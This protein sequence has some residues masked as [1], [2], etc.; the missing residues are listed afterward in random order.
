MTDQQRPGSGSEL[1]PNSGYEPETGTGN[2]IAA[3]TPGTSGGKKKGKSLDDMKAN[4][5]SVFGHGVGKIAIIAAVVTVVIVGALAVRGLTARSNA[6]AKATKV[7]VPDAPAPQITVDPIS[8]K[9]AERRAHQDALEA[10]Q[11][12]KAGQSYQPAFDPNISDAAAQAKANPGQA[13]AQ[14]GQVPGQAGVVPVVPSQG[15]Q[16]VQV[17]VPAGQSA[18]TAEEQRQQQE[19][20]Q[21]QKARAAYVT[22][23]K[24]GVKESVGELLGEHGKT[25]IRNI[26]TYSAVSYL[27]QPKAAS[28]TNSSSGAQPAAT[29]SANAGTAA[30][31]NSSQD[32]KTVFKAGKAI[33]AETDA[34][35]DT[36]DGSDVFAT[37]RGGAYD[38]A[39][40]I[41]KV[42]QTPRNIRFHFNTL[43]PQDS[44]P[45]LNINAIAIRE[46]DA[47]Q[48][49][50]DSI[51]NHTLERYTALFAASVLSGISKAAQQPQGT[52]IIL[53]NGQTVTQQD[54]MTNRRIAMYALGE[55]GVNASGEMRKVVDQPATYKTAAKRGIG[56]I[57]LTDVTTNTK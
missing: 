9:E 31:S 14:P 46:E 30:G 25:G 54:A 21:Q 17:A 11:A 51:D 33:F 39:K 38:G 24:N 43:A 44:R 56:V 50:A 35:V 29:T 7:D 2:E 42:E 10:E 6:V 53:P 36:D 5:S 32:L 27:P 16:P 3:S 4:L 13:S 22:E 23:L 8:R 47:K 34:E 52:T 15:Q 48:G 28:T 26:G 1:P 18:N 40:L 37:V 19:I 55:V 45:T 57:F 20:A 49:V 12:A 41:G